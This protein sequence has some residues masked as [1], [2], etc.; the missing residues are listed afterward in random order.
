VK[1]YELLYATAVGKDFSASL[2][3]HR[4]IIAALRSGTADRAERAIRINWSNSA[5]RLSAGLASASVGALGTYRIAD[6]D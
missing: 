2:R 5:A 4:A 6:L 1:R 3:E